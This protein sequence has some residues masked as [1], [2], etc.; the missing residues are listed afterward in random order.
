M[1]RAE[2]GA[3]ATGVSIRGTLEDAGKAYL[4]PWGWLLEPL[5]S[6]VVDFATKI[7]DVGILRCKIHDLG[8]EWMIDDAGFKTESF[9]ECC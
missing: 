9:E 8:M 3:A 6:G 5:V 7:Y 4:R 1:V 2:A